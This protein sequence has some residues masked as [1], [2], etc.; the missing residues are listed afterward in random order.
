MISKSQRVCSM[1]NIAVNTASLYL[2]I[3]GAW[4]TKVSL[5]R[6]ISIV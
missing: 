4:N 5:G 1:I 6:M 3:F 2:S